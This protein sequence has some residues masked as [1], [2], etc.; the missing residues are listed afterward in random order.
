MA[1]AQSANAGKV[2]YEEAVDTAFRAVCPD[3]YY[4]YRKALDAKT[5][6]HKR[7]AGTEKPKA[8]KSVS[9]KAKPGRTPE[10]ILEELNSEGFSFNK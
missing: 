3:E 10:E 9:P 2:P 8:K 6:S 4:A 1:L 5:A 7:T